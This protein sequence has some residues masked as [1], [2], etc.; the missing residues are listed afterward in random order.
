VNAASGGCNRIWH[1]AGRAP[2]EGDERMPDQGNAPDVNILVIAGLIVMTLIV[3]GAIALSTRRPRPAILTLSA[4]ALVMLGMADVLARQATLATLHETTFAP[5]GNNTL[6]V[7]TIQSIRAALV[8]SRLAPFAVGAAWVLGLLVT[9][10]ARQW[11]WL[12]AILAFAALTPLLELFVYMRYV[13]GPG[14]GFNNVSGQ[15]ICLTVPQDL[16][17]FPTLAQQL[18]FIIVPLL[19][20]LVTLIY[21]VAGLRAKPDA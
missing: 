13:L 8:L 2:Q 21:G 10:R 15:F 18:P 7:A 14:Q 16:C 12:A 19:A 9:A 1:H 6:D 17:G 4:L 5:P 11:A 20:P 3:A